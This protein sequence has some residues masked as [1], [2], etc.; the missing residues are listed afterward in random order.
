M[1]INIPTHQAPRR[2]RLAVDIGG[3][4]TDLAAFDDAGRQLLFGKSLST[5]DNLVQGIQDT[6]D[7][8]GVQFKDAELFLHGSTIVINTLLERSGAHTALLVTEGFRDIYEIGRINRPD[9]YNLYFSKH[10]PLVQRSLRFEVEERLLA[11]GTVHKTLNEE[12]VRDIARDLKTRGIEAVAVILLHSYSNDA[13][14]KRVKQILQAELPDVFVTASHELSKEYREFERASTVAANAYVGPRVQSY[15]G[16]LESHLESSGF[17]GNFY[18]VQST[19]G[20][21][22]VAE[23]RQ[24]CV[25]MLESGP[26]AG[27]IGAQAV[28][29][30]LGLSHAIAFDMGGTTAKAGVINSGVPLTTGSALIGGYARALPIQIPMIDIFE[31]GTGGGSIAALSEGGAMRVGPRSAGSMP[32]PA[33]YG[34][35][36]EQPTVTDANLLLGRLDP[37]HFLGGSMKLDEAA[38]TRAVQQHIA[39]PLGLDTMAAADGI[40]RIAATAMSYAVKGV[41]TERGLDAGAFTMIVYGGAGPLHASAI[42]RELGIRRVIIPFSPGHFSAYGMLFSDLRYDYVRSCFQPLSCESLESIEALYRDM[43][44]EGLDAIASSATRPQSTEIKRFADMRYVGQE[45]AVTV[46]LPRSY[47]EGRDTDAIKRAFDDVHLQRYGTCAPQESAQIVS[48][49]ISAVGKMPR[50]PQD[51]CEEESGQSAKSALVRRKKVFFGSGGF[52]DT[53]IYDRRLLESGNRI[54]GPALIEEHASTTVVWPADHLLV[55]T[56]GNLDITIGEQ[57]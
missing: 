47:F 28:C 54:D 55:D 18:T 50:P 19:G 44:Q 32:G 25:R 39:E 2:L 24:H 35:G 31:V 26:A 11:D 20:L 57:Q 48:V 6:L 12:R 8:A 5:H 49:R 21:Y 56:F 17:G 53:P 3:T 30:Q 41:T 7:I 22:P 33:C 1:S 42:A 9:A 37:N 13:H 16:L 10:E 23:A 14:E 38:A 27:V 52:L 40:L 45:H 36:G 43:E 15:L 34:R 51:R 46:E 29:A 4:F